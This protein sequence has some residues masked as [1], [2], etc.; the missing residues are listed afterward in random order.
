MDWVQTLV[1]L[2]GG[3]LMLMAIGLPIA[4]AFLLINIVG[5]LVYMG[6]LRALPQ[7]VLSVSDSVASFV[8]TPVPLF[9][10]M[11][12]VMFHSGLAR[13]SMDAIE[14][15][16][17]R[18]P[19]RLSVL[20]VGAGT[21]FASLTGSGM[22]NTAMLGATL[23]PEMQRRGYSKTMS[24]GPIMA[25]GS[26]AIMIPPSSLGVLLGS[27][28]GISVSGI[29]IAGI[30]PGL[31][32]ATLFASY[33][34]VSCILRPEQAPAYAVQSI[35]LRTKLR[36]AAINIVPLAIIVFLVIGTI[37]LGVAT[38]TESAALGALGTLLLGVAYRELSWEGLKRALIGTMQVTV[39]IFFIIAAAA[40]FS[41]LLAFTGAGPG[42]VKTILGLDIPPLGIIFGMIAIYL[43]LG[44]F[45]EQLAIMMLTLPFM[46]PVVKAL[47]F[48]PLWFG[49]L[50]LITLEIA[51]LTPPFGLVLFVMKG[52]APPN[53]TMFDI[54]RAAT[55]FIICDLIVLA[56]MFALP[57]FALWL[58]R[59][60]ER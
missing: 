11:G 36:S 32:M 52:A 39:M 15:W 8:F 47:G 33:I 21:V 28:A 24:M 42:L 20:S 54:Y 18:I 60:M 5:F 56:V 50:V 49:V 17:G 27:L 26:L 57:D 44:C 53:V 3:L 51:V 30:V 25:A 9:I 14:M 35:P 45:M 31:L 13:R 58:P 4:F 1:L 7:L 34:I 38:P 22:A 2:L 43:F 16:I 6:G 41:Q 12:E 23:V 46:M 10:L 37:L 40:A 48:D 59:L 19:G 55:P 29:L